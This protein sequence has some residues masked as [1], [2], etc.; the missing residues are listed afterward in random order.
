LLSP[1]RLAPAYGAPDCPGCTGQC[2]VPRLAHATNSLLSEKVGGAVDIIHWT[3]RCEPDYPMSQLHPR[4]R[5][6]A[7]LA[8]DVWPAPTVTRPHWTVWCAI[9]LSGVPRGSWLQWSASPE[10]EGDRTLLTVRWCIRLSGVPM[11]RR[12]LLPSKWRSNGS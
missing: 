5:S 9:G 10:K 4:Q 6:A 8:G 1:A 12:Q 11:D 7:Q 2:P 3:V